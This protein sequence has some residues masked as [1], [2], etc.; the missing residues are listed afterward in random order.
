MLEFALQVQHLGRSSLTVRIAAMCGDE[1]RVRMT[2]KM[3]NTGLQSLRSEPLPDALREGFARYLAV[4][5]T[6]VEA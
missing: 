1:E 6:V 3:V 5:P 2:L 4:A